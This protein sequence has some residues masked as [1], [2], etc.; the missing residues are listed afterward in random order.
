MNT[1]LGRIRRILKIAVVAATLL[2]VS[3]LFMVVLGYF[4][5]LFWRTWN[6]FIDDGPFRGQPR[7][8][9][10]DRPPDQRFSLYHRFTLEVY[11]TVAD[12]PAPTVLLKG[13]DSNVK[14]C[15]YATAYPGSS[16]ASIRFDSWRHFPFFQPRVLALVDWTY[17][18]ESSWWFISRDGELEQY[19]YSW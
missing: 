10:P 13:E 15:I 3:G 12:E 8:E 5:L 1:A 11:D 6:P 4:G 2:L 16:V 17:G 14:W 19:W 18:H 7:A 9:A